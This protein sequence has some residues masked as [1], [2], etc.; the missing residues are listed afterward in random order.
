M[1][2]V[3]QLSYTRGSVIP[4]FLTLTSEDAEAL[5]HL[6]T[7][8][9]QAVK[10]LR[11]LHHYFVPEYQDPFEESQAYS[12]LPVAF[13]NPGAA[14][15]GKNTDLKIIN[16]DVATA[17]WWLPSKD[18]RQETHIRHLEG[19]IHLSADLQPSCGCV[20]FSIEVRLTRLWGTTSK[21]DVS[22]V[23]C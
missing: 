10:L 12:S 6:S 18:I 17:V 20:I 21:P 23:L 16:H 15:L 11:R 13:F 8:K 2:K 22:I 4:C 3:F 5:Q 14:P 1:T 19:E 9:I 7:P